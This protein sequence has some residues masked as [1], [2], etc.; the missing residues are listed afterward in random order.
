MN[1]NVR[2]YLGYVVGEIALVIAGILIA[3]Q[4][5]AWYENGKVTKELNN[6]L[7]AV[8]E[9]ISQDLVSITRLKRQRIGAIFGSNRMTEI[10]GPPELADQWYNREYVEFAS[11]L[12]AASQVPAYFVASAGAYQAVQ[13]SGYAN[14]IKDDGLRRDLHD[15]YSTVERIVFAEREMNNFV[16]EVTLKYQTDTT[17]GF[18]KPFLQEP[19]LAWE[20]QN[21]DDGLT[22]MRE[23]QESYRRLLG[24]SVTQALIRSGRNQ[25]LLK[26]YEHLLSLGNVL[27]AQINAYVGRQQYASPGGEVFHADGMT[28]PPNVFRQGRFEAHSLGFFLASSR[29][30]LGRDVDDLRMEQDHLRVTYR[31]CSEWAFVYAMVGPIDISVRKPSLDYSRFDRIRLELMRDSG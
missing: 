10:T 23:F 12:L 31:G 21:L 26:E 7:H 3:L 27:V 18:F 20:P 25:S 24:D 8:A 14:H 1:N 2:K 13:S 16:H 11:D 5:D 6:Q 29:T 9:S 30:S 22:S 15:Y 17:R 4:I 19:L 28:G